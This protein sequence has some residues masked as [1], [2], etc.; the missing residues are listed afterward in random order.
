MTKNNRNH[1][2]YC[3]K[4]KFP[5]ANCKQLSMNKTQTSYY[6]VWSKGNRFHPTRWFART[7][8]HL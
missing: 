4:T 6:M 7:I 5:T 1:H 3:K 2:N 8:G